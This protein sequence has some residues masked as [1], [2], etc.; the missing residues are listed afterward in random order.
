M[1]VSVIELLP[2]LP[3]LAHSIVQVALSLTPAGATQRKFNV[4]RKR[5]TTQLSLQLPCHYFSFYVS[6]LPSL[7]QSN[8]LIDRWP[9][10]PTACCCTPVVEGHSG[11]RLLPAEGGRR[12]HLRVPEAQVFVEVIEAVDKVTCVSAQRWSWTHWVYS[13]TV[14]LLITAI[15]HGQC[16]LKYAIFFIFHPCQK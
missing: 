10:P 9:P 12:L 13:V 11:C 16:R 8:A 15:M 1:D 2:H 4:F 3:Q 7:P 6:C 5:L 14:I